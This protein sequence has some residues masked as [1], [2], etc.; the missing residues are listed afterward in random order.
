MATFRASA[1]TLDV[2][3]SEITVTLPTG[4]VAGDLIVMYVTKTNTDRPVTP[5][6]WFE[7]GNHQHGAG[8]RLSVVACWTVATAAMVSTGTVDVVC[9]SSSNDAS[10][11]AVV[12]A[13]DISDWDGL[14]WN[15]TPVFVH[16]TS[17]TTL[18]TNSLA[19]I[20]QDGISIVFHAVGG[21]ARSTVG[22]SSEGGVAVD[23]DD[24]ALISARV[25]YTVAEAGE[26]AQVAT[27]GGTGTQDRTKVGFACFG[28]SAV[29]SGVPCPDPDGTRVA[30]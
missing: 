23:T 19:T 24:T 29:A 25:W 21:P 15:S 5:D 30:F 7:I 18:D 28:P 13:F 20:F 1:I 10:M 6:G 17:G 4:L 22:T 27:L 16:G 3:T 12:L 11:Y 14:L 2:T 26:L 9:T 8:K